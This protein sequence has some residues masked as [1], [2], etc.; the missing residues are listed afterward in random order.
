MTARFWIRFRELIFRLGL[1]GLDRW[2]GAAL[3]GLAACFVLVATLGIKAS[4]LGDLDFHI[5]A[6]ALSAA[7]RGETPWAGVVLTKAPAPVIYYA[8]P[9]LLIR[10]GSSDDDYWR[11]GVFWNALC[12]GV[13]LL[14]LRR[15]AVRVGGRTAGILAVVLTLLN[16]FN[17]YY[18]F[19]INAENPAYLGAV[20]M[21]AAWF[22]ANGQEPT[23]RSAWSSALA[24]S[25]G[26]TVLILSRPNAALMVP[27]MLL[28][29]IVLVRRGNRSGGLLGRCSLL[30]VLALAMT[31]IAL[32]QFP[33]RLGDSPQDSYLAHVMFHGSYQYRT[34][35]WDWRFWDGTRRSDSADY[36]HWSDELESLKRE[37]E[38]N[39]V[40]IASLEYQWILNDFL[41]NPLLRLK[42]AAVRVLSMHVALVNSVSRQTFKMGP[43]EGPAAYWTVHVAINALSLLVLACAL[44]FA[45]RHAGGVWSVWPVWSPW[46]ALLVFHAVVYAEPRYLLPARP[47]LIVGATGLISGI[48]S[49]RRGFAARERPDRSEARSPS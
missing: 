25:V 42:M 20:L 18:A 43:W 38:R 23:G 8:I 16:P 22:W 12:M 11:A 28:G 36:R 49:R 34:E 30:V 48:L 39:N 17:I 27:L 44:V 2:D 19:G 33:A 10:H 46:I 14:L 1:A 5:E 31:R 24:V 15:A 21:I 4:A 26:A 6:K 41:K 32:A 40:P 47:G 7:L 45:I 9:Y 13:S 3:L 37:A 29:A 35:T